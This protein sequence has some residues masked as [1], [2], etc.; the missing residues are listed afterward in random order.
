[1]LAGKDA[2]LLGYSD[3][4]H[5][6]E[7]VASWQ[8]RSVCILDTDEFGFEIWCYEAGGGVDEVGCSVSAEDGSVL[9]VYGFV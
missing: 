7:I 8:W 9:A 5:N 3:G 1:M 6:K 4:P 2:G